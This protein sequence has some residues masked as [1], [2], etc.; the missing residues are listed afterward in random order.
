MTLLVLAACGPKV[1]A[2]P[3]A[4]NEAPETAE[5][6]QTPKTPPPA[7]E[8]PAPHDPD[9]GL[10]ETPIGILAC[11]EYL[12][13]YRDCEPKLEP[14]IQAGDRRD[15]RHERGWI[16][17]LRDSPEGAQLPEACREMTRDLKRDCTE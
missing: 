10:V 1:P 8:A 13:L 12:A 17:Y 6:A 5:P 4:R 16:E 3:P 11:D 9:P 7:V 14:E 15:Y 2:Q